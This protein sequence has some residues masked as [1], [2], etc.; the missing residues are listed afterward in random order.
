MLR[1]SRHAQ[2]P[3]LDPVPPEPPSG[4]SPVAEEPGLVQHHDTVGHVEA[5]Q[6]SG[7]R[8]SQDFGQG[9]LQLVGGG[10]GAGEAR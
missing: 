2:E 5:A 6:A 1:P 9:P 3:R 4:S 7:D 8:L 10:R